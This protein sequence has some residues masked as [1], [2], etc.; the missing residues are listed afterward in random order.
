MSNQLLARGQ[1][2]IVIQEDAYT[3][4][5]SVG[6]YIFAADA[7]G[8][9]ERN[10]SLTSRISVMHGNT[11]I[12]DFSIGSV[13]TPAGF[14]SI[15][16]DNNQHTI[17]YTVAAG[18]KG[19][20]D[21]GI[22]RIPVVA[23]GQTYTL[24]FVW[25][26]S[27]QGEPGTA[28]VLDWVSDWN[29]N[30]TQIDSTT[31]I[32]P[33]IFA[34]VKNADH[35]LTGV[36]LGHFPLKTVNAQGTIVTETIDGIYGFRAGRKTFALDSS[37]SVMLGYEDQS[38]TYNAVTGRIEFGN[39]VSLNWTNAISQAKTEV[40]SEAQR[41]A[42]AALASAKG[43]AD[44]KKD[45]AVM[46]AGKNTDSKVGMLS[47][48]LS[49]SI[50]DA[51]KAGTDARAVAD[52]LTSKATSEGW[53]TKLTYIDVNGIFTGTLTAAQVNA[54]AINAGSI[55]AGTLSAERIA[56]G[57]I[58]SSKL[59]AA[60]IQANI[61]N[62]AYVNGLNCTF[63]RGKIGGFTIGGDNM[64]VGSVG[65]AGATPLQIRSESTGSGYWYTGAYKP[66][67]VTLTWHQNS[68]AGHLVFGQ[69]AAS[70][71]S[72]KTGFIGLQ[73]MAWDN[74]EYFCLST[75]YT[76]SGGKEVYN[77]IAGWAFDNTRIWKNSVSL[78]GDGS[79]Y[80]G[81]K[82]RLNND[83]SGKIANGAISWNS[84][85]S[86]MFSS[87]VALNWNNAANFGKLYARGT[88]LNHNAARLV[89]LNGSEV[90]NSAS[91]GLT[92]TVINRNNL[93]VASSTNY[94]VYGNDANCNS[95]ASAL[96][97][98]NSDKIVVLTSY[99]A[100]SINETLNAALQRCG[101][102][103]LTINSS[104]NPY[105]LIGIPTIGKDN[106]LVAVYGTGES[107]PYAE[108]STVIINGVPQGI[109]VTGKQKTYIDGNGVYTGTVRAGQ[110]I[111]DST[112]VVGGS[113][114]NGSISVR[115]A[116]NNAKVTLDRSGIMAI[117]GTIGGFTLNDHA[118]YS[119]NVT[120]GH[121]IG[122]QTNGYM[123]NC[124]SSTNADYWA[125]NT[126][127]SAMFG[128]G[129]IKFNADGSG[130]IANQNIK[131]DVSGNVVMNGS[132]T[133]TS[134]KIAGFTISGNKLVNTASDSSIEFS[135]MLGSASLYIN[136]G[137]SLISMRADS[138]RTGIS[139]Q[140]Y[141][142]GARG[143]YII[144]NA[145][146]SYAIEAY[147][148]MQLGQRSGE[149]WCVPGVLYIGCK[150]L[151]GYNSSYRKIWGDGVTISS[152]S[153]IGDGKYRVYHNLGHT[154]YTVMAGLW[155]SSTYYGFFRLLERTSTY[156]V[157]QNVGSSGNPDAGAFDFV[158]MGRN[159][160]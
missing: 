137:S 36:A 97:A 35:T 20:A 66:L 150:Y 151:T 78:G 75:N 68:N 113:S 103:N 110:V 149:R 102:S 77:R 106:G 112:L 143:M 125:L 74:T 133:A 73:M 122:I 84:S 70:G 82:W 40:T 39:G 147:G 11:A 6:Q 72:V 46:E 132:I 136:S 21:D 131:W 53:S 61:I 127:G 34:G 50:T 139:I 38:I 85:G 8:V 109:N 12:N 155:S 79:I 15:V 51:K 120:A 158:I 83:G 69:V 28:T 129:K 140:T 67:G 29:T 118:L 47:T 9:I 93:S 159:K 154:D 145:G 80:N 105:V 57:S 54:V 22:I 55:K 114:Y 5:Q 32:T 95:L 160:W 117:G 86:V 89:S 48:S 138:S 23:G 37:G 19:L 121:S 4:T 42:D 58:H 130:Y 81:E 31:L 100:I 52:A 27:K 87:A 94:D 146:S 59:D 56:A 108:I 41:K 157:I 7:S 116:G 92:L 13:A 49:A 124:N 88:G 30:K 17:T 45:E 156:F 3:V 101:G 152:F 24:S 2:S 60:S 14:T 115:D 63:V 16:V 104:R 123:Y 111:I 119:I 10:V 64:T 33:K 107:E 44:T 1:I 18:S 25:S 26:K 148:P 91:R 126:D 153:H 62:A 98:L 144:A 141:A 71:N 43:Y 134:G 99:D 128:S 90:V 142:T 76:K 135:S 65:A 96:N